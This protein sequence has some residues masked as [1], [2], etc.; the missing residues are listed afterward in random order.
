MLDFLPED[1]SLAKLV[2]AVVGAAV[3]VKFV[4]GTWYEVGGMF[5][6]G[7]ALSYYG[8]EWVAGYLSMQS[9]PGLVGFGVGVFG[10]VIV[11]KVYQALEALDAKQMA[12]D[13]W[14]RFSRLWKA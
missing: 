4:R 5:L 2:P 14:A 12:A 8:S 13:G 3:S 1:L 7:S 9:A 6:G 11:D 10:M